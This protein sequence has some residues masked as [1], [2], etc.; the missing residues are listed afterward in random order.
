MTDKLTRPTGGKGRGQREMK[1]GMR[2]KMN[3]ASECSVSDGGGGGGAGELTCS[4]RLVQPPAP[5]MEV[6]L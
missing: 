4:R 6:S 2:M 5:M 3:R 1:D